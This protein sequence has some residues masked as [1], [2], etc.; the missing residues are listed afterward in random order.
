MSSAIPAPDAVPTD[1][2]ARDSIPPL[3]FVTGTW[4]VNYS[5]LPIWKDKRNVRITYTVLP[6]TNQMSDTTQAYV[7]RLDDLVE[8][9]AQ[10]SDKIKTVL[11]IDTPSSADTRAWD[12]RG[13]GWFKIASSHWEIVEWSDGNAEGGEEWAVIWFQKTIFSPEGIDIFSRKKEGLREETVRGIKKSLGDGKH[14]TMSEGLFEVSR[15]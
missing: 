11:G 13:K 14:K 10:G 7:P 6:P 1:F 4:Y 9:Q 2:S 8:Y 5:T 15:D 12:W 3:D